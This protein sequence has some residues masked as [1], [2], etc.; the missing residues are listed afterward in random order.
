MAVYRFKVSFEDYDDVIREIDIRSTQT[1]EDLHYAIHRTTGYKP[2]QS[3]SFY[4]SNDYWIKKDEIAYLPTQ[5]KI[6]RG[7]ALM[8]STKLSSFIDDPHQKFY[9]TYNFDRPFDFHVELIKILSE[10][11]GKDYPLTVKSIGEAPKP[12]GATPPPIPPAGEAEEF[13][14]LDDEPEYAHEDEQGIDDIDELGLGEA[15]EEVQDDSEE[16]KDDFDDEFTDNENFDSDDYNNK[17]DY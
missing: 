4:V 14:F 5:R 6:D 8:N 1:F 2:E 9:Y 13:D 12:L 15:K 11:K 3:S 10:E 17:E 16:E 7:V